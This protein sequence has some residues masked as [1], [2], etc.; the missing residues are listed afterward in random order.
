M[1]REWK[2]IKV[3]EEL[4][5]KLKAMNVGI[6]KAIEVLLES[7]REKLE[8]KIEDVEK[9]GREVAE[10]LFRSGFFNIRVKGASL[11][12]IEQDGDD[13]IFH[14]TFAITVPDEDVRKKIIEVVKGGVRKA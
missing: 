8:Q 11:D 5:E 9:V 12:R 14:G 2:T 13:V 1:S 6:S 10:I 4:Y 3:P 7:Q